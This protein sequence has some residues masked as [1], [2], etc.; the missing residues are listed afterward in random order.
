M[1]DFSSLS[2]SLFLVNLLQYSSI[3]KKFAHEVIKTTQAKTKTKQK[4]AKET[5]PQLHKIL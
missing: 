2:E 3:F 1:R 4:T 5:E